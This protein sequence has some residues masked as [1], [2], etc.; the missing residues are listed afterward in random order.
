[1]VSYFLSVSIKKV[2]NF[3]E[4]EFFL[5]KLLTNKLKYDIMFLVC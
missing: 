3:D 2:N 5:K 1:M 4:I